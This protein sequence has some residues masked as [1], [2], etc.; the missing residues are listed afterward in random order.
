MWHTTVV[1]RDAECL[2]LDKPS[3]QSSVVPLHRNTDLLVQF[4]TSDGLAA[5]FTQIRGY[6][7]DGMVSIAAPESL[8]FCERRQEARSSPDLAEIVVLDN[9]DCL[10][11]NRSKGGAAL[12]APQSFPVG[13]LVDF[14]GVKA[15]VLSSS[16]TPAGYRVRL[17]FRA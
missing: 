1:A 11:L 12:L 2:H 3:N 5:F 6:A 4:P 7:P 13:S 15:N 10:V 9:Q 8:H 14:E 17:S 16:S